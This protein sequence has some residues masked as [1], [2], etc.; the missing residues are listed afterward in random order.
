MLRNIILV[1]IGGG[2]GSVIRY[3]TSFIFVTKKFPYATFSV[4]IIGSFLI[5]F[6]MGYI[7]RQANAQTWQM[8]FVTGFCGGFTTFSAFSWEV[9]TMLQQQRYATATLYISATLIIGFL[10]TVLGFWLCK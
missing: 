5:G 2:L 8:L 1:A 9:V 3:S 7:I 6:L 4:N 10:F